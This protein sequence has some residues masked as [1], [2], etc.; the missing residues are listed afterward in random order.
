VSLGRAQRLATSEIADAP[1]P[2]PRP[3]RTRLPRLVG[4]GLVCDISINTG[5]QDPNRRHLL[6]ER[7]PA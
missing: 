1:G 2:S 6:A 7:E 3:P 4:Y 5:P